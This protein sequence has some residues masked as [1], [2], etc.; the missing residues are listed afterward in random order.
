ML[1][2]HQGLERSLNSWGYSLRGNQQKVVVQ[3]LKF[4]QPKARTWRS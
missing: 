1:D 3:E 4:T 2:G